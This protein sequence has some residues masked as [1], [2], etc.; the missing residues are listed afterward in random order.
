M[1]ASELTYPESPD[2]KGSAKR[3][4]RRRA[5]YFGQH[6][7]PESLILFATWKQRLIE[8]GEPPEVRDVRQELNRAGNSENESSRRSNVHW[9]MVAMAVVTLLSLTFSAAVFFSTK[10]QPEVDGVLLSSSEVDYIRGVRSQE[11]RKKLNEVRLQR[12]RSE[13][14]AAL[15]L[16]LKEEGPENAKKYLQGFGDQAFAS[17]RGNVSDDRLGGRP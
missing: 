3:Y 7:T 15:T 11:F 1:N 2:A 13:A 8:T 4:F 17:D 14:V 5:Y 16:K 6:N 9:A 12:Q 10:R